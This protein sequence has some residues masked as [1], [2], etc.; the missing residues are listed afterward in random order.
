M[1]GFVVPFVARLASSAPERFGRRFG[2][3][4]ALNT[5]GA[6]LGAV[7]AGAWLVPWLGT[8]RTLSALALLAA[9][10]S[11][12]VLARG[13]PRELRVRALGAATLLGLAGLAVGHG[14]DPVRRFL[15]SRV[16]PGS[17][18]SYEEGRVQTVAV[19][20]EDDDQRLSYLRM[21]TN[22]TSLTGTHLYARRYMTLLGHLPAIFGNEARRAN[23]IC[24]GTGMTAAAVA[25]Y[26]G[27]ERIDIAEISPAVVAA[28]P[29]FREASEAVLEDPR[30]ALHV[31]DGRHVLL[32][33]RQ[34]WDLITLEPPPPRDSG[35]VSLYSTDFYELGR[36]RLSPGGVLAQWIPLHSQS[37]DEIRML[38][39]SFVE[40]FP[41]VLGFLPVERE[42]ILLGSDL[43]LTLSEAAL[44]ERLAPEPVRRSL[45][46]VGLAEPEALLATALLDREGLLRLAGEAPL[47]SDDR[48]RVE[49][50]A[51]YGRRPSPP[52]AAPLAAAPLPLERLV[53]GPVSEG[54]RQRFERA[55][56]AL[57]AALGSVWAF[58][59]GRPAEGKQLILGALLL[60]PEDPYLLWAAG[61]SD[62]H[63]ER[64]RRR[65]ESHPEDRRGWQVLG[66]ALM[67]RNRVGEAVEAYRRALALDPNDVET[68]LPLGV[69]LAESTE[70]RAEGRRYLIRVLEI[71]PAHPRAEVVR[72][73]LAAL[74]GRESGAP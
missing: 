18:L 29:L 3:V 39:R 49:Y 30:V 53:D 26:P 1:L 42:L 6:V 27:V 56:R 19:L 43:P 70:M 57:L 48:P 33:G 5:F 36:E 67:H 44:A 20:Q 62:E 12:Y 64:M 16:N 65:A 55:R 69:I 9:L 38:V 45:A 25:S 13:V 68:L 23:V 46:R 7:A 10:A 72:R 52:Q 54:F 24:L 74:D 28:A 34:P 66:E 73:L 50:F 59:A 60:R 4:Y 63:L 31:E 41:H 2:V 47:V 8:A 40:V 58:E 71:A 21:V 15:L 14:A 51:R 61:L 11:L 17:V 32:A 22:Q 35:V 37:Q